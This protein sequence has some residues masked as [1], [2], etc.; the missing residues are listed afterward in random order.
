MSSVR[1][2]RICN[3]SKG[4]KEIAKILESLRVP[5]LR[6]FR[7]PECR[8][9]K[10]LAFDFDVWINQKLH[11]IEFNGD[12]HYRPIEHFGGKKAFKYLQHC[13]GIKKTFCKREGIPLLIIKFNNKNI[14]AAIWSF[15]G[16]KK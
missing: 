13:D 11:L 2:K 4:E 8:N 3:E 12:Q 6:Q 10:P 9:S 14:E 1:S 7:I 5:F 16:V 15:L